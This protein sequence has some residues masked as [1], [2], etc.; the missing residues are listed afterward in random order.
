MGKILALDYGT[1]LI[2]VAISDD[3][4]TFVFPRSSIKNLSYDVVLNKI[5]QIIREE[6]IEEIVIGLP[7]RMSGQYS[8]QTEIV[9]DFKNRLDKDINI[10][11]KMFDERLTSIQSKKLKTQIY[12]KKTERE[13]I[14]KNKLESVLIL[15]TYLEKY[16][17][18]IDNK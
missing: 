14:D 18:L 16:K 4:K 9:N 1:N 11:I 15:E 5:N 12:L 7:L 6:K 2:G 3:T 17:Q 10:D 13:N 8:D